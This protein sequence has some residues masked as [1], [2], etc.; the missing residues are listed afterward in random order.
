MCLPFH[1]YADLFHKHIGTPLSCSLDSKL[2][3]HV[4]GQVMYTVCVTYCVMRS[5]V[6]WSKGKYPKKRHC[7][8]AI[9]HVQQEQ[10]GGNVCRISG[11]CNI[12]V[13]MIKGGVQTWPKLSEKVIWELL[14]LNRTVHELQTR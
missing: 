1:Y 6:S 7:N 2:V 11:Y 9:T 3:G 13:H 12:K 5:K 8:F 4:P 10:N 14:T